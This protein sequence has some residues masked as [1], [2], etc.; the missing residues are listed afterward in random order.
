MIGA[1]LLNNLISELS[2]QLSEFVDTAVN[3]ADDIERPV[4]IL[5][6]VPE[7]LPFNGGGLNIFGSVQYMNVPEALAFKISE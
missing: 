3:I 2:Q 6:V 4:L 1:V 7:W 5:P